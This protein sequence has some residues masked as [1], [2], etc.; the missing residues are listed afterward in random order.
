MI[1]S[2]ASA[3]NAPSMSGIQAIEVSRQKE[4]STP[5]NESSDK[6]RERNQEALAKGEVTV[7][8]GIRQVVRF[9][10]VERLVRRT[11]RRCPAFN[12]AIGTAH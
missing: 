12:S 7:G 6:Y 3:F 1:N 4:C 9:R 10:R 5:S 8:A 2:P 11:C